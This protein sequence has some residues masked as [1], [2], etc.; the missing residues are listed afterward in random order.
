M[1]SGLLCSDTCSSSCNIVSV[2]DDGVM[3]KSISNCTWFILPTVD[4]FCDSSVTRASSGVRAR[5]GF[6]L[7][8]RLLHFVEL[9]WLIIFPPGISIL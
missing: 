9:I 3:F 1:D 6:I 4:I 8:M 7:E 2:D 5:Y